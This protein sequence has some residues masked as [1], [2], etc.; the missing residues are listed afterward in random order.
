MSGSAGKP[1]KKEKQVSVL[2]PRWELFRQ[3]LSGRERENVIIRHIIIPHKLNQ[4][5][6]RN[7]PSELVNRSLLVLTIRALRSLMT[8]S[9]L[10]RDVAEQRE[11]VTLV[12]SKEGGG[13]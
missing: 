5:D 4:T 6:I 11:G 7:E 12:G 9:F 1:E 2:N 8:S 13:G 3:L 10:L